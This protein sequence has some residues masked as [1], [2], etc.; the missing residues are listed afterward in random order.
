MIFEE[1]IKLTLYTCFVTFF[2]KKSVYNNMK[3]RKI[4]NTDTIQ[5]Y[6]IS[7][8]SKSFKKTFPKKFI[9]SVVLLGKPYIFNENYLPNI[10]WIAKPVG[11][12][13]TY[14]NKL[15]NLIGSNLEHYDIGST[16]PVG[17]DIY[18]IQSNP[19]E[20]RKIDVVFSCKLKP[21]SV[22]PV[23]WTNTTIIQ[24]GLENIL[25]C[26]FNVLTNSYNEKYASNLSKNI[27]KIINK[28]IETELSLEKW[29]GLIIRNCPLNGFDLPNKYP[30]IITTKLLQNNKQNITKDK[31]FVEYD[32]R[33]IDRTRNMYKLE[34]SVI[35]VIEDAFEKNRYVTVYDTFN[36]ILSDIRKQALK[37]KIHFIDCDNSIKIKFFDLRELKVEY[38]LTDFF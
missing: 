21:L 2:D 18:F 27:V 36:N 30:K 37:Q 3:I 4:L 20:N 23:N 12:I 28:N 29:A 8:P 38:D 15:P 31:L 9:V 5:G 26:S 22:A 6:T 13:F 24:C 25:G 34:N 33:L 11:Y 7:H 19:S 10:F 1:K 32:F 35:K 14:L 16:A 17:L